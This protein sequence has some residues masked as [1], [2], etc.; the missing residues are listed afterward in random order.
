MPPAT[1]LTT[2][3]DTRFRLLLVGICVSACML[4]YLGV[5][6]TIDGKA[7][8]SVAASL[9][10][11]GTPDLMILG[12]AEGLLPPVSRMGR[13]G[14]DGLLYAK[15]GIIPSLLLLPFIALA[16][17]IPQLPVRATAM[18]FNP[19]VVT[20]TALL[21]YTMARQLNYR[22]QTAFT[23]A[24][25]YSNGTLA[26][27]YTQT[28]FGEPLAGL[29]LLSAI[30]TAFDYRQ[31]PSS[32]PL[33]I[34]GALL[35]L[36]VGVNVSYAL[37][38]PLLG[39]YIFG[40]NP[41]RWQ[42][43]RI[44]TMIAPFAV[45]MALLLGFNM[46][47]FGTPLESGYNFAEG[48]GFNFPFFI[49][50]FGLTLSPYGG[51]FWFNPILWLTLPGSWR[52]RRSNPALLGCILAVVAF[53]LLTYAAWWS[54]HGGLVWGPRFAVPV[55]P[56]LVLLLLPVIEKININR[57]IRIVFVALLA[58]SAILQLLGALYDPVLYIVSL[59]DQ[60]A[61]GIENGFF[62]GLGNE[63]I[64]RP[65]LSPILGQ[66]RLALSGQQAQP[67]LF[68]TGHSLHLLFA[69]LIL[70]AGTSAFF[71]RHAT[72][73]RIAIIVMILSPLG[74]A[75]RQQHT[76]IEAQAVRQ[77]LPDADLII[78]ATTS[79]EANLIDLKSSARIITTNAPTAPDDP[80]VAGLW[81]YAKK[82][83]GLA[84]FVTWFPPA[85]TDNWQERDLWS[86]VWFVR[87][88]TLQ[89]DRALLFDLSPISEASQNAGWHFGPIK[90]DAYRIRHD[91]DGIRVTLTWSRSEAINEDYQWFVHLV[92]EHSQIIQQ[93]DRAPQGGYAPTSTWQQDEQVSD[94]LFFPLENVDP[95]N[96]QLRV[97]YLDAA[98]GERL[99]VSDAAGNPIDDGFI[100]LPVG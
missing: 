43:T 14:T 90:I 66:I 3:L 63:V 46:M 7:T 62:S 37:M 31:R 87:E 68:Q 61:T 45:I 23:A 86:T 85:S 19:L 81:D 64:F 25:T 55:L 38:A 12:S 16:H 54:W 91:P 4:V 79:Y 69:L 80:L 48:E 47:R 18:L 97:G 6:V 28:L 15:K 53:Q 95:T 33:L 60:Y 100:L 58:L 32:S 2:G 22:P 98:T 9:V 77:T 71:S 42:P 73:A 89:G 78:A 8:L 75:M 57:I 88:T 20:L 5:P 35:G 51:L 92:D 27:V 67:A 13:F 17:A 26:L 36:L 44:L 21:I 1:N 99:P 65:D 49:G 41:R 82:Q 83:S 30:M 40:L 29:L 59:Y 39:L 24:L 72:I 52:F 74:V 50:L 76:T 34:A 10:K 70:G 93:Q 56:M 96:W 94:Y 11:H 84:W